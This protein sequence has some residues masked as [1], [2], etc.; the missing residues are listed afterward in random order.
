MSCDVS[1]DNM[2]GC[3]ES[4][5]FFPNGMSVDSI[6]ECKTCTLRLVSKLSGPGNIINASGNTIIINENPTNSFIV[7]GKMYNLLNTVLTISGLH[8]LPGQ[9]A[10]SPA[11]LCLF[12]TPSQGGQRN[13][14]VCLCIPVETGA[15]NPYF[16]SVTNYAESKRPTVGTLLSTSAT[17]LSYR[18]PS[19]EGRSKTNPRP[20]EQC[21][22]VKTIITYYVCCTPTTMDINDFNRFSEML[23]QNKFVSS[24]EPASELTRERCKLL[25]RIEGI[26]VDNVDKFALGASGGSGYNTDAMKCYRLDKQRDI[27]GD[28]IYVNG[29]GRPGLSS[30]TAEM[31]AAAAG[32]DMDVE[33]CK[34]VSWSPEIK[35]W[36]AS[37]D[38]VFEL[39]RDPLY[40]EGQDGFTDIEK[41]K[42]IC[43]NDD[44]CK[45]IFTAKKDSKSASFPLKTAGVPG[46]PSPTPEWS[47]ATL[48]IHTI[49][50]KIVCPK[51]TV[52]PGDIERVLGIVLGIVFGLLAC[53][54]IAYFVLKWTNSNYLNV[55]K[56]YD[57]T[58]VTTVTAIGS[59]LAK[60]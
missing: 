15:R 28:K 14:V 31:A 16:S 26:V 6:Y 19:I 42:A 44:R 46:T 39:M 29:N 18:G 38:D 1:I 27:V 22:P 37:L 49:S 11:E 57:T 24:P 41:L 45:A 25:T 9:N 54:C 20:R 35:T 21:S 50:N 47:D 2:L 43:A 59:V 53:A 40:K 58:P 32:E 34:G 56:L 33:V 51:V 7:N 12:F 4:P 55:L 60:A 3:Q 8:R 52:K 13:E 17:F 5:L 30:L 36:P 23:Q 48:P 10:V